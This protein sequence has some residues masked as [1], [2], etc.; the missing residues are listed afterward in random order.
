[1]VWDDSDR[2]L[3]EREYPEEPED[4]DSDDGLMPCPYCQAVIH[5]E[6]ER[7]PRCGEY[8]SRE[9]APMDRPPL[10]IALGVLAALA[11]VL[12]WTSRP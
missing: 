5:D 1:M 12:W 3:E 7:C 6:T 8:L 10:W 9:S 2:D 11:A 4:D